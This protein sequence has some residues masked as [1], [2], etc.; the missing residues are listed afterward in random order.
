MDRKIITVFGLLIA[1]FAAR[2]VS[3]QFSDPRIVSSAA[4]GAIKVYVAD[5]DRDGDLD[6][7]SASL[8]DNKIAWYE[9]LLGTAEFGQQRIISFSSLK[10][11]ALHVADIDGDG[12]QDVL[13]ASLDDN[14]IA[15]YR[16]LGDGIFGSQQVITNQALVAQAVYAGDLDGD[17]DIDVLSAS[18]DD[19]KIAWYENTNGQ[20][21]FSA[22]NIIN[23]DALWANGVLAKDMDGDG[24]LDV[25]S[26]S[27]LDD[28]IAWYRN[29]G[30]GVFSGEIIVTTGA[31]AVREIYLADI[32]GDGDMDIVSASSASDTIAWYENTD[33][34][35]AFGA[36]RVITRQADFA[37]GVFAIDLDLD[38]DIDVLSASLNDSKIAWYENTNGQG[39]FSAQKIIS[40]TASGAASV[41]AGNLDG[42]ED[43]DI[44]SASRFDNK[45]A[46]YESFAGKGRVQFGGFNPIAT[47][48]QS[49]GA[50]AVYTADINGDGYKDVLSASYNDGKIAWYLN[51][52]GRLGLQRIIT[53]T[54]SGARDVFAIDIDNDGDQDVLSASGG[55]NAIRWYENFDGEG[56]FDLVHVISTNANNAYAVF[57]ADLDT[58]GDPDVLSAS[59]SDDKIAWYENLDGDGNFSEERIIS[60]ATK[61]A[62]D[63]IAVDVDGDGDHDVVSASTFDDKIAWYENLDG[64]GTFGEQ[65]VVTTDAD[66][67]IAI[68]ASDIDGDGDFDLV[69]ASSG[70]NKVAWY[71]NLDGKGLFSAQKIVSLETARAFSVYT[72]DLDNDGD[73]DI[74][75][76]S[77]DDNKLAWYENR[78]GQIFGPQQ[79]ITSNA[80]GAR[81]IHA[82]DLDYDG[83]PDV[84]A[85]SQDDNTVAW[86]ENLSLISSPLAAE[87]TDQATAGFT[88]TDVYPNPFNN[89]ANLAVKLETSQHVRVSVYDIQGRRVRILHDGFM[90]ADQQYQLTFEGGALPAGVYFIRLEGEYVFKT[91]KSVLVK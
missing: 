49:I 41:V 28:K 80:Q 36:E 14:K 20:G 1:S 11:N 7:L 65:R 42:D 86:Y 22:A 57:A 21:A 78:D 9:N 10:V 62:T 44:L 4:E 91:Q 17:G 56:S 61:G 52:K 13:A 58:D 29:E 12:N 37:Q 26:S 75:S 63:V 54:A 24:D 47:F 82:F 43:I 68:H 25:V 55:D 90:V 35:G 16:N 67:A 59:S 89:R 60:K 84:I 45:I 69:S 87:E 48:S 32:D 40:S 64:R 74:L 3:A 6:V 73:P 31:N 66:L 23:T 5:L 15:W 33:G 70:D 46:W 39:T 2:P 83:D 38:G 81:S 18:R 34:A 88:V 77:K 50:H 30:A 53:T 72:A 71:E 51:D 27:E 76:A 79:I 85:A 19:N 8:L